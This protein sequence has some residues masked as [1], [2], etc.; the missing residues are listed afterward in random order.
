MEDN[1]KVAIR[2]YQRVRK[3]HMEFVPGLNIIVGETNNGKSAC[4]ASIETAIFNLSRENHVTLGEKASAV[5]IQYHGHEVIWKRDKE[6]ASQVT[7]RVDSKVYAKV[8]KGQFDKV[9]EALG[10]R[11]VDINDRHVRINFSKQMAYPFMLDCT[12]SELFK[13]VAQSSNGEKLI[14]VLEVMKKDLAENVISVKKSEE[15]YNVLGQTKSNIENSYKEVKDN[16]SY[17]K[18]VIELQSKVSKLKLISDQLIQYRT[19]NEVIGKLSNSINFLSRV[20]E[21]LNS[22]VSN[23]ESV[24]KHLSEVDTQL[25]KWTQETVEN[26]RIEGET[27]V[28]SS[29]LEELSDLN[30]TYETFKSMKSNRYKLSGIRS[31]VSQYSVKLPEVQNIES[32]IEEGNKE[33]TRCNKFVEALSEVLQNND[34]SKVTLDSIKNLDSGYSNSI[35]SGI[36]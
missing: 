22:D 29:Q 35:D 30:Q 8:G 25:S 21:R 11:E 24:S 6:K 16:E 28:V 10:I 15:A 12:P 4:V 33:V 7:Y 26:R 13:F 17:C 34:Q 18:E 20:Y 5:G 2:N 36:S 3:A 32:S 9:A 27:R 14:D 31:T 23:A 19:G 1:F